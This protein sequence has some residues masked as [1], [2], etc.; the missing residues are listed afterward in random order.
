MDQNASPRRQGFSLIARQKGQ[1]Y[2]ETV[3]GFVVVG[4]FLFGAYHLWRYGEAR[5]MSTDA[6]R[7]AAWERVAWEPS[8]N[9]VEKHALHKSDANLAADTVR[10]QLSSPKA[11]REYRAGIQANGSPKTFSTDERRNWLKS[12]MKTFVSPGRDPNAVISLTTSSGWVNDVE[13]WYRGRDPTF[14]TTT[15][16]E[17]DQDTYRTVSL[18]FKSQ[19]NAANPLGFFAFALSPIDTVKKL[20][21][22]T[23]AWNASPPMQRLRTLR[24]LLPLSYG[25]AKS[26]TKP[27]ALAFFGLNSDPDNLGASDFVGMVPWWNFVAGPNGM[28][29]QYVVRQIGL[30]TGAANALLQSSGQSF[31]HNFTPANPAETLLMS[32]QSHQYEYLNPVQVPNTHHRHTY[33]IDETADAKTT[34]PRNSNLAKKKYRSV[35]LQNPAENFFAE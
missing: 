4:L 22:I 27:N 3:V 23:N 16:L 17:L 33:L 10:H 7:F 21:L 6:V 31:T 8:D 2:A 25:D 11:V 1:A 15:S 24:Q 18:S 14:N 19:S 20:S 13:H 34:V 29:G 28:A 32:A 30:N 5:Q 9:S 26:G 35:S 12:S